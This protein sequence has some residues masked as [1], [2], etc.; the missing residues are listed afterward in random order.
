MIIEIIE[1]SYEQN[2]KDIL[3]NIASYSDPIDSYYEDH[4]ID[5][6]H[7]EIHMG[8]KKCGYFSVFQNELLTQFSLYESFL[9]NAQ[10]I[11]R[12]ILSKSQVKEIYLSTSDKLLLLMALDEQKRT[13]VQDLIFQEG[14]EIDSGT[15]FFIKKSENKD[16]PYIKK[17]DEGFFRNLEKNIENGELFI[18]FDGN[19]IVSYGIIE[20]SKMFD[21]LASIGMFVLK[22]E[23]GKGYGACTISE[24]IV[25]CRNANIRPIAGCFAKNKYSVNALKKAGMIS[26]TR[27]LKVKIL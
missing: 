20:N 15:R 23:R 11:F 5:S 12:E 14:S 4:I 25:R 22:N 19:K 9:I 17:T 16:I 3:L 26:K 2:K 1:K 21:D 10:E 24:L 18:G 6:K 7:Y 13:I 8:N 27:L